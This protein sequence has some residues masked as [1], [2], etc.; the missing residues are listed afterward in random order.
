[1]GNIIANQ[2]SKS[3][4]TFT[5]EASSQIQNI[6]PKVLRR[7]SF[8]PK[9]TLPHQS[10]SLFNVICFLGYFTVSIGGIYYL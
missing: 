2:S 6:P 5:K 4:K 8:K 7:R 3:V 10:P 9:I 1:M